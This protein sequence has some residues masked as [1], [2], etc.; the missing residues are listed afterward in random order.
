M[1]IPLQI[2]FHDLPHSD[3][4]EAKIREKAAKL[5]AFYPRIN[6]CRVI[7]E[8]QRRHQHQG[9]LFNVRIDLKVPGH[10]LAVNRDHEEDV[11]V[12]L[13]GAFDAAKRLLEDT[14]RLQRGDVKAHD[15]PLHGRIARIDMDLG[16]GYIET[17]DGTEVYFSRANV[18]SPEFEHLEVGAEVQFLLEPGKNTLLA[19]R[20]TAGKHSFGG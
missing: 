9:K 16:H 15:A 11:F 2:T 4:L 6:S 18:A 8:E 10:E 5:E 13:R 20:V 17:P 12:A 7:V 14:V 3:A 1:Q 19:K